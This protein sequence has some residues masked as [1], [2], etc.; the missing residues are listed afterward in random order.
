MFCKKLKKIDIGGCPKLLALLNQYDNAGG[1]GQTKGGPGIS[2]GAK[3]Y[4]GTKLLIRKKKPTA[5]AFKKK[6]VTV[7]RKQMQNYSPYDLGIYL[8]FKPAGTV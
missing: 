8:T 3:L 5:I 4:N 7:T 6:S 1:F 2:T